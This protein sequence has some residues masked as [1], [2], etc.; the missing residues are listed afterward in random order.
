MSILS[1][2]GGG[3]GWLIDCV[4]S[5]VGRSLMSSVLLIYHWP[6]PTIPY[7][8]GKTQA[9]VQTWEHLLLYLLSLCDVNQLA[10]SDYISQ[11]TCNADISFHVSLNKILNE[12]WVCRWS[13]KLWR[14][15]DIMQ[16]NSIWIW[17]VTQLWCIR[18]GPLLLTWFNLNPSMDK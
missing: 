12:Q 7:D 17:I 14:S 18:M 5:C 4:Y 11:M 1:G 13:E 16:F 2:G 9:E 8:H 6:T 10:T 3:R 15:C